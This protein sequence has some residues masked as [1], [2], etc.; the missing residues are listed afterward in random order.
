MKLIILMLVALI[1]TLGWGQSTLPPCPGDATAFIYRN[2]CFGTLAY[3]DGKRF[4]G[5]WRDDKP[6]GLG[7]Y[8][9]VNGSVAQSGRWED[10]LVVQGMFLDPRLFPFEANELA[11]SQRERIAKAD[12]ERQSDLE[13]RIAVE[14]GEKQRLAAEVEAERKKRQELEERLAAAEA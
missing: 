4:T 3:G 11:K 1:P 12:Q 13:L 8:F 2:N 5:E 14:A 6:N 7:V 10:G 9:N